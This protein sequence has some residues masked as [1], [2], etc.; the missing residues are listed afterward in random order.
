LT[1]G[2]QNNDGTWCARVDG[3]EGAFEISN[4]D[5]NTLK[6]PVANQAIA[7]AERLTDSNCISSSQ[8]IKASGREPTLNGFGIAEESDRPVVPFCSYCFVAV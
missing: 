7:A 5:L 1:I 6:L 2:V 3:G 4:S 8:A